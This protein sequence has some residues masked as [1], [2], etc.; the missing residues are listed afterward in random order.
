MFSAEQISDDVISVQ[1]NGQAVLH[2]VRVDRE[3]AQDEYRDRD[4]REL[5]P[6]EYGALGAAIIAAIDFANLAVRAGRAVG[7]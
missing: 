5:T 2:V 4:W 7:A 6:S 1:L 3:T